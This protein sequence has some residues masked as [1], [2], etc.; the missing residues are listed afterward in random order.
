[1]TYKALYYRLPASPTDPHRALKSADEYL[2]KTKMHTSE[3]REFCVLLGLFLKYAS[4]IQ[5]PKVVILYTI[6]I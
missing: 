6:V 5:P 4:P 3:D 1:M 2:P